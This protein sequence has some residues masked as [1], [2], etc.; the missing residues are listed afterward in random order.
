MRQPSVQAI[1]ESDL[2]AAREVFQRHESRDLFYRTARELVGI[3]M[4][5]RKTDI[6]VAEALGTLLQTWNKSFYRFHAQFDEAHVQALDDLIVKY[7]KHLNN[8]RKRSITSVT[9]R[10]HQ[11]I[12]EVFTEFEKILGPVGAA[13]ALHL[14]APRFFPL[15][16]RAIAKHYAVSMKKRGNNADIYMRFMSLASQQVS[17]LSFEM[18][19]EVNVL[20]MIDEYNYSFITKGWT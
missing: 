18:I 15:W 9:P 3:A 1:T 10:D 4:S 11:K 6:T 16:D 17:A 2:L 5:S 13:K 19:D 14:I 20:K 8:W 7:K 12:N